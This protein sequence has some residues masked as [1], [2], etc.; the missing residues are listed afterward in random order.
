MDFWE[1][2]FMQILP[3]LMQILGTILLALL[4]WLTTKIL[5]WMK[6][7]KVAAEVFAALQAGVVFAQEQ[8][9]DFAKQAAED[10]K[11]TRDER[12][13]AREM[14]VDFAKSIATDAAKRAI[15]QMQAGSLD[16]MIADI[17]AQVK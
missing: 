5:L 15:A 14:A 16:A 17:V 11:L 9:V 10:G 7:N 12:V 2:L 1:G 4:G 8:F 6:Q 13:R 3:G